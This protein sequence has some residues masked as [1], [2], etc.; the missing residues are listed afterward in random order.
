MRQQWL[1][2]LRV[3]PRVIVLAALSAALL[4]AVVVGWRNEPV[5]TGILGATVIVLAT[6][7][8]TALRRPRERSDGSGG[9]H[10]ELLEERLRAIDS[11][12][13]DI[14]EF[15]RDHDA[16]YSQPG[17]ITEQRDGQRVPRQFRSSSINVVGGHR[18]TTQMSGVD[19]AGTRSRTIWVLGGSTV[20]CVESPDDWTL[21]SRL[22]RHV[23]PTLRRQVVNCGASGATARNRIAYARAGIATE[24]GDCVVLYFGVNEGKGLWG[25]R[26]IGPLALVHGLP[27]LLDVLGRRSRLA[28][29]ARRRWTRFSRRDHRSLSR[30]EAARLRRE[31]DLLRDDLAGEGVDFVAVLQ[32][33]VC[34]ASQD[35]AFG[36]RVVELWGRQ[37]REVMTIQYAEFRRVFQDAAYFCDLSHI[38][39]DAVDVAY[40]DWMHLAWVGNDWVAAAMAAHLAPRGGR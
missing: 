5:V 10:R 15:L 28:R 27:Q 11:R 37:I 3:I 19:S 8:E 26:G 7:A 16:F 39:D 12:P 31:C 40:V 20:L 32:P 24:R 35:T 4:G 2:M 14:D 25:R 29:L 30:L 13:F 22:A 34:V 38:L 21:P 6:V 33:N 36:A 1:L 23:A 9:G 17:G 18:R